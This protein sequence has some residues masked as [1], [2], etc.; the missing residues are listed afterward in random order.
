MVPPSRPLRD[1]HI[2]PAVAEIERMR[3][4]LR[5]IAEHGDDP[6][7]QNGG[8]GVSIMKNSGRHKPDCT[9]ITAGAT[10]SSDPSRSLRGADKSRVFKPYIHII[11]RRRRPDR[12]Y[13]RRP[14]VRNPINRSFSCDF[15]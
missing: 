14:R 2:V 1:D 3:P 5:S 8:I 6:P 10:C 4:A 9:P 15:P 7:A 11:S 13:R 12:D